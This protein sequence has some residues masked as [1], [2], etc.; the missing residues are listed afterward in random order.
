MAPDWDWSFAGGETSPHVTSKQR[1]LRAAEAELLE[2]QA[3][4]AGLSGT[5]G[6]EESSN[7]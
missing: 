7:S 6:R 2:R 4:A 1:Q 3:S 5:Q